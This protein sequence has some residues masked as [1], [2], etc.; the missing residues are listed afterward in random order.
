M[1]TDLIAGAPKGMADGIS[2][3]VESRSDEEHACASSHLVPPRRPGIFTVAV[4][5][6]MRSP[7]WLGEVVLSRWGNRMDPT[8]EAG[9]CDLL[10]RWGSIRAP[11]YATID[12]MY[13]D[14]MHARIGAVLTGDAQGSLVGE[15][16][17][18]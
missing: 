10:L 5:V 9:P 2:V 18:V 17:R 15:P 12:D 3:S 7:S 6:S 14:V 13:A 16:L 8:L 11:Q 1:K 4:R